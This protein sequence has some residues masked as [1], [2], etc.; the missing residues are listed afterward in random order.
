M[1]IRKIQ[2]Q[3]GIGY[4]FLGITLLMKLKEWFPNYR[5]L[6]DRVLNVKTSLFF[7]SNQEEE[8]SHRFGSRYTTELAKFFEH[9][10]VT[11]REIY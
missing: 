6:L 1:F 11:R 7:F 5:R 4:F 9:F 10:Y 2:R 3:M 8:A